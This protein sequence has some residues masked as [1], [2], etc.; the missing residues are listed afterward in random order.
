MALAILSAALSEAPRMTARLVLIAI[1]LVTTLTAQLP[2]QTARQIAVELTA[3][4]DRYAIASERYTQSHPEIV[5]IKDK[6]ALVRKYLEQSLETEL[7]EL[8]GEY[9]ALGLR[10]KEEHPK[11]LRLAADIKWHQEELRLLRPTPK[12]P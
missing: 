7:A 2:V 4:N 3:L 8:K 1:A 10:Y 11:M 6:I 9:A 5:T 12:A